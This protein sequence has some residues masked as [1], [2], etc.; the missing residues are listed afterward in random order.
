MMK[1]QLAKLIWII[2]G[3][4]IVIGANCANAQ[5]FSR[6][7]ARDMLLKIR[8]MN[9]EQLNQIVRNMDGDSMAQI[10][11][12]MDT[13][14]MS[15]IVRSLDP[16][17][18]SEIAKRIL[19]E[20]GRAKSH[21]VSA[22][23]RT[24]AATRPSAGTTTIDIAKAT[25]A[26]S[27]QASRASDV[28]VAPCSADDSMDLGGI[29][30]IANP[31]NPL[32]ELTPDQIRKIYTGK[33]ANWSQVGGPNLAVKVMIVGE[34]P[35]GQVKPTSDAVVSTF[36]TSVFIGVAATQGAVGFVPTMQSRQLRFIGG[37]KAVKT[38]AVKA[39]LQSQH[40]ETARPA[41]TSS[42]SDLIMA[43]DR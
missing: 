39:D 17:T 8:T 7:T 34:G 13:Y 43:C 19:L 11:R 26:G 28:Q 38:M 4:L 24:P 29:A 5:D 25:F 1:T 27:G 40:P 10:L 16:R 35:G 20:L 37:N 32:N 22:K 2:P 3:A 36:A 14:T 41:P 12:N 23:L 6:I 30:I 9:T 31:S 33:Y 42:G 15:Q 18:M 21:S